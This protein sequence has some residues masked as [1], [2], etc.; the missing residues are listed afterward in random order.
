MKVPIPDCVHCGDDPDG[1]DYC[2]PLDIEIVPLNA[3]AKIRPFL[4]TGYDPPDFDLSAYPREEDD[5]RR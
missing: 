4:I 2:R 1:C 3:E 5:E